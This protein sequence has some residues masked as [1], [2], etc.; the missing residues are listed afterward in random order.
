MNNI[1]MSDDL[2]IFDEGRIIPEIEWMANQIPGGFFIYRASGNQDVLYI[3]KAALEIYGC[4]SEDEFKEL[5][6]NLFK[7][8]IYE[9][10][11][12]RIRSKLD[13]QM[14]SDSKHMGHV[15]YRIRRKDGEIRWIDDY[16]HLTTTLE[17]GDIFCVFISDITA[18]KIARDDFRGMANQKAEALEE[19]RKETDAIYVIHDVLHSGKWSMEFDDAGKMIHVNWS[20]EFRKMIGYDSEEDFPN[21]LESWSNLLH[22][23]DKEKVLRKYNEA[24]NDKSGKTIYDVKYRLM[25]KNRGYRWYR[26]IGKPTRRADGTP[27]TYVGMFID[28]D[29]DVKKDEELE[30]SRKELEKALNDAEVASRSK[31]TFLSNMSHDIRTPMNAIIGFTDMALRNTDKQEL[32]EEYLT[33]I[34]ASS[35]HLL[36]LINEVLEMSR[37]ESGKIELNEAP[38]NLPDI[39]RNLATI[40]IGQI[41]GKQQEL[42]MDAAGVKNENVI[43]DKLRL[44][45]VLLNLVS[46]SIKYTQS[47]GRISVRIIQEDVSED[48]K[49]WYE[50]RIKDNGMGMSQE[51]AEKIFDAFERENTSTVSGIQGTG[52]GMTITKRLV[53]LMGGSIRVETKQG[54]GTEFIVRIQF[55]VTEGSKKSYSIPKLSG[56]HALVVD[57]DYETC[58]S[59]TQ[60]LADMNIRAEWTL[61]GKEAVLR[62]VQ[63]KERGDEFGVYIVDWRLPDIAGIEVVRRIREKVGDE[64]PILLITAYDWL[65]IRD[66]AEAAGVNGFC[67]K[68]LFASELHAALTRIIDG[69]KVEEEE[70]HEEELHEDFSGKRVLLVD[71]IE[72]NRQIAKIILEVY[73]LVVEEA[74]DGEM[75]V[76]K[77]RDSEEGYFDAILMDIQMPKMNGYEATKAIR[78]LPE[79]AG[80]KVPILA[81]TANAFDEDRQ[82]AL[83]AGMNGHIAKP[84]DQEE[85]VENLKRVFS[86]RG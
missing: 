25:T 58:D 5:T 27:E 51:F 50:F 8:M 47:G 61:S 37:I 4:E 36:S 56:V 2:T 29:D 22:P 78:E 48:G 77:F 86:E 63:A 81:M 40:I 66:E 44:D 64:V 16:G 19:L 3:N 84:I 31:T 18:T 67:N 26:A 45:Q 28:I 73:G 24:I 55:K 60:L 20:E 49:A 15:E 74:E 6:G 1:L 43:C 17:Y 46:N 7:N 32:M 34:K 33:K 21:V 68:P 52:L 85:L 13:T 82:N 14:S 62:A 65:A 83:D 10:D 12:A 75:A 59:T 53:D 39:L 72:I 35:A 79:G 11:Y 69:D 9:E 41:E 70:A 54:V 57:D 23:D 42:F 30:R 71:D 38:V 76:Q 80:K